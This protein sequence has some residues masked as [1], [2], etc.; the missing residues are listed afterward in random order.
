M[1]PLLLFILE[2]LLGI[3]GCPEGWAE[4]KTEL[5]ENHDHSVLLTSVKPMQQYFTAISNQPATSL[6][7]L[8]VIV[9]IYDKLALWKR[10]AQ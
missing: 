10:P 9:Q 4:K 5:D 6:L 2:C 8:L 3:P 1:I 7:F